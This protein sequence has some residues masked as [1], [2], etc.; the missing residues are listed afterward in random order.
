MSEE[1]AA[2]PRVLG[3]DQVGTAEHLGG[4]IAKITEISDGCRNN[5]QA[6]PQ[7]LIHAFHPISASKRFENESS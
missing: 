4:A 2:Y 5:V 1:L 7:A 6:G 3:Q